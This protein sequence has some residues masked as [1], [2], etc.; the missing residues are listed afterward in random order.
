MALEFRHF[1]AGAFRDVF[2]GG[3]ADVLEYGLLKDPKVA[4]M[5]RLDRQDKDVLLDLAT[6]VVL[7]RP[8]G[9][10]SPWFEVHVRSLCH[11]S[12]VTADY[13]NI[14]ERFNMKQCVLI[15]GDCGHSPSPWAEF[16]KIAIY[17]YQHEFNVLWF[18]VPQFAS[19]PIRYYNYGPGLVKGLLHFL[20]IDQ[21]SV[22]GHGLGAGIFL[23]TLPNYPSI[24]SK[25]HFLFNPNL[26][27]ANNVDSMALDSVV[28]KQTL[29]IWVS[30]HD[31]LPQLDR[32]KDTGYG[33]TFTQVLKIQTRCLGDQRK[34]KRILHFDEILLSEDFKDTQLRKWKI[35]LNPVFVPSEEFLRAVSK[36]FELPPEARQIDMVEGL[37]GSKQNSDAGKRGS[38]K[39]MTALAAKSGGELPALAQL[40]EQMES[41]MSLEDAQ[42]SGSKV[43]EKQ[44]DKWKKAAKMLTAFSTSKTVES[45]LSASQSAPSLPM[46]G[47][48]MASS[49]SAG[50]LGIPGAPSSSGGDGSQYGSSTRSGSKRK[51]DKKD[52][53]KRMLL[54][55]IASTEEHDGDRSS[56]S[57]SQ[58]GAGSL[59]G[60]Q[61]MMGVDNGMAEQRLSSL[62]TDFMQTLTEEEQEDPRQVEAARLD[63]K[64]L[65]SV[66]EASRDDWQAR[67]QL[68][69]K[70]AAA[71][72]L[73]DEK[74][75][76]EGPRRVLAAA[77]AKSEK[78]EQHA[79]LMRDEDG[80]I[81]AVMQA[82]LQQEDSG[83]A[84]ASGSRRPSI[85]QASGSAPEDSGVGAQASTSLSQA[86]IPEFA[87]ASIPPESPN[88]SSGGAQSSGQPAPTSGLP[89]EPFTPD[90]GIEGYMSPQTPLPPVPEN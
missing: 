50:A 15:L 51:K 77:K 42:N 89:K 26:P 72:S 79:R 73:A 3:I 28:H 5:L 88:E 58:A 40:K 17:L 59:A 80:Q 45:T 52:K 49:S 37:I 65:D 25:T 83:G 35:G 38:V 23:T 19:D 63:A 16:I 30:Y 43:A 75:R 20:G 82:S 61:S 32:N 13:L 18:E 31:F 53:A 74:A 41:G 57:G 68:E 62:P 87:E 67:L 85:S 56:V 78:D 4:E 60:T 39:R 33:R 46:L 24:F 90:S 1:R 9:S 36:F 84:Q 14:S 22:L 55:R 12:F 7:A 27:G 44:K 11:S 21:V 71:R 2:K 70:K 48:G 6:N 54:Q 34:G 86:S 8:K 81:R 64:L 10:E 47:A 69:E 66:R 76:V 29:Q